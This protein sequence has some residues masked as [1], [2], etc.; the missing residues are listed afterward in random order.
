MSISKKELYFDLLLLMCYFGP[1]I[2][3]GSTHV[4]ILE[5]FFIA[6]FF[7]NFR[8]I[9]KKK[10][11]RNFGLFWLLFLGSMII[12]NLYGYA[13]LNIHPA[14]NDFMILFKVIIYVS[15]YAIGYKFI[16][17]D[18]LQRNWILS[19]FIILSIILCI[20]ILEI[21]KS[22]IIRYI[23]G[24]FYLSNEFYEDLVSRSRYMRPTVT[25]GN[26][27]SFTIVLLP[28][29]A[30]SLNY[31][32]FKNKKWLLLFNVFI[33]IALIILTMSRSGLICM[34]TIIIISFLFLRFQ[35]KISFLLCTSILLITLFATFQSSLF[36]NTLEYRVKVG[37]GTVHNVEGKS[38]LQVRLDR[39]KAGYLKYKLSPILGWGSNKSR[40]SEGRDGFIPVNI[41]T[42]SDPD[43]A[44]LATFRNPHNQYIEVMMKMGI[45]GLILYLGFFII[46][47]EPSIQSKRRQQEKWLHISLL[48]IASALAINAFMVGFIFSNTIMLP[49]L[50]IIGSLHRTIDQ[51]PYPSNFTAAN[52]PK[53]RPIV[54]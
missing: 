46:L 33:V 38:G 29:L 45:P 17:D 5:L 36:F 26:T 34:L 37:A 32:L 16:L 19:T 23:F 14:Y 7:I 41:G 2:N 3:I 47:I 28:L 40:M 30:T 18:K 31:Y 51:Y 20:A 9:V 50:F 13:F 21:M 24:H 25:F 8:Y 39:W 10:R 1:G 43:F 53:Y 11:T 15:C 22:P 44:D 27:N 42:Q 49:I 35:K 12:S 6:M 4:R 52:S 54:T 48:T